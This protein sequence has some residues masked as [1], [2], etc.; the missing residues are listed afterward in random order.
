MRKA[1]LGALIVL[2][3]LLAGPIACLR[4]RGRGHA[5]IT[6][7]MRRTADCFALDIHVCGQPTPDLALWCSNHVSWLDVVVIGAIADVTFVSK[8]EVQRWPL[9]GWCA[10]AAG[11]LF[12]ARGTG[13]SG[14]LMTTMTERLR[15]GDRMAFSRKAQPVPVTMSGASTHVYSARH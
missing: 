2:G 14:A 6:W 9:L 10:A 5:I 4:V 3:V 15:A 1:A 8:A 13:A 12:L 7:W 11:T